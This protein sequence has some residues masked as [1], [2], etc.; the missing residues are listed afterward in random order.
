MP[1]INW[2]DH[3]EWVGDAGV[4][5]TPLSGDTKS[6]DNQLG[7]VCGEPVVIRVEPILLGFVVVRVGSMSG[8]NPNGIIW[9]VRSSEVGRVGWRCPRRGSRERTMLSEHTC[10]L[11]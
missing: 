4:E 5:Y 3:Q 7:R 1:P 10:R 8:R 6:I 9:R 11:R 2:A